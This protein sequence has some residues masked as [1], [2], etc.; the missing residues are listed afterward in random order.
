MHKVVSDVPPIMKKNMSSYKDSVKNL[1][2]A[3]CCNNSPPLTRNNSK[4]G[5]V[6]GAP[7]F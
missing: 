7:V 3:G 1:M 6:K 2:P 4:I 5:A